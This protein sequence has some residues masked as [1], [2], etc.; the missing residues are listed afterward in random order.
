MPDGISF[1]TTCV[2]IEYVIEAASLLYRQKEIG[3]AID[4]IYIRSSVGELYN[5]KVIICSDIY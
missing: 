3:K 2:V 4:K 5:P 1:V